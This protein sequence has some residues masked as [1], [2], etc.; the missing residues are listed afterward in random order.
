MTT[1]NKDSS[2]IKLKKEDIQEGHIFNVEL[3][4]KQLIILDNLLHNVSADKKFGEIQE[5]QIEFDKVCNN[6]E[7]YCELD[8]IKSNDKDETKKDKKQS[9]QAKTR[10]LELSINQFKKDRQLV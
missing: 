10:G 8:T 7:Q 6:L 4:G 1:H 3:T 5:L 2:I 9:N